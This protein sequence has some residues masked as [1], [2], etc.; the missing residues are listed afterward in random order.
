VISIGSRFEERHIIHVVEGAAWLNPGPG[1][2][3]WRKDGRRYA[4]RRGFGGISQSVIRLLRF[5]ELLINKLMGLMNNGLAAYQ[6]Q[7][8]G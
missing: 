5:V 2:V 3:W 8:T 7:Y 4:R 6:H 1:I